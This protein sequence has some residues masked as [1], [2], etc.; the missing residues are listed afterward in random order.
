MEEKEVVMV[1]TK[2]ENKVKVV[3]FEALKQKLKDEIKTY[4]VMTLEK[5]G[6]QDIKKSL[7]G[8]RKQRKSLDARRIALSKEFNEPFNFFISQVNELLTVLDGPIGTLDKIVKTEEE[9]S[10]KAE[11]TTINKRLNAAKA[12]YASLKDPFLTFE[13]AYVGELQTAKLEDLEDMFKSKILD[14]VFKIKKMNPLLAVFYLMFDFDE[15]LAKETL[16]QYENAASRY[17]KK[18]AK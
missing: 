3:N 13:E 10:S 16:T 2:E 9:T 17:D 12:I 7:A 1:Y 15:D 8:L 6:L 14:E 5:D 11:S 4:E 18:F